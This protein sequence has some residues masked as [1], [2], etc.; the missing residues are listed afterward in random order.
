MDLLDVY[1]R[2]PT[3]RYCSGCHACAIRCSGDVPAAAEEWE[4]MEDYLRHRIPP[5][6]LQRLL[7]ESKSYQVAAGYS[8]E[9]C[10]LYDMKAK[11]CAVYPV[12]PLICRMLGF[13]EWMPCPIERPLPV[14][15]EGL[16]WM[17]QYAAMNPR[18]I[19]RWVADSGLSIRRQAPTDQSEV[20][21][22][23]S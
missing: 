8:I 20:A 6:E 23:A 16:E 9:L 21:R 19:P 14:A 5:S 11:S 12:R 2:L 10:P 17:R 15:T 22:W 4:C 7:G 1:D 18:P 13:V 3:G